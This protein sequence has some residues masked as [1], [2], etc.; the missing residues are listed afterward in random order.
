M[1]FFSDL[2]RGALALSV[3]LWSGCA[4]APA[5]QGSDASPR[6]IACSLA[7]PS[8]R[9]FESL[10]H[11]FESGNPGYGLTWIAEA[12]GCE[13]DDSARVI[14]VQTGECRGTI[15]SSDDSE[16]ATT[17]ELRVGDIVV[18]RAGESIAFEPQISALV[19][20]VPMAPPASVPTF[21]RPD[22]DPLLT[23][24]PG[25][26]AE[27]DDAYRRI[28]L[29]WQGKVGPYLYH[30][31][32]AHRVRI[33]DSFT[34]YHPKEGGFDEFYLVQEAPP[35][36]E[37]I[38]S[39]H[40]DAIQGLAAVTRDDVQDLLRRIPLSAG[41]LIYLPRTVVHRGLGGAVVQVITVPGFVPGAEIGVDSDLTKLNRRLGLSGDQALPVHR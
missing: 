37:L 4:S 1:A 23:D 39:E 24:T 32:N 38:V 6:A 33:L 20:D 27:E 40:L 15:A 3:L 10:S 14:F 5:G 25:G 7:G 2:H 29:T 18:L 22:F 35:G 34:H 16:E 17:S 28:L 21:V 8:D 30:A 36:A 41:D 19:F 31:I 11:L 9:P 26:C 12:N 13:A